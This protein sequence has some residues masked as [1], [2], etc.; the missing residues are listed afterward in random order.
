L[1]IPERWF[2]F[3]PGFVTSLSIGGDREGG[4]GGKGMERE[5]AMFSQETI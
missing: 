2:Q 1:L 4:R 5:V 3:I